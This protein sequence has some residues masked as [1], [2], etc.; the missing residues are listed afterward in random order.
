MCK[1][2]RRKKKFPFPAGSYIA[3]P[4]LPCL[5]LSTQ[6]IS[7]LTRMVF[8]GT[9]SP[10]PLSLSSSR[11]ATLANVFL[12]PII[13]LSPSGRNAEP[14]LSRLLKGPCG[15]IF[16]FEVSPPPVIML[17][18][19]CA[20]VPREIEPKIRGMRR[21]KMGRRVGRQAEMMPEAHS[22][23]HQVQAAERVQ[24]MS[25]GWKRKSVL[26]R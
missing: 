19:M 16:E 10:L 5:L 25:A 17:V 11:L 12:S 15:P 3:R 7:F 26:N 23:T 4:L 14:L 6:V 22:T 24:D 18:V 2:Q 13:I 20:P 1:I 8:S 9:S 21:E